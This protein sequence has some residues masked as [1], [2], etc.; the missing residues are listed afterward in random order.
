MF[1]VRTVV[2]LLILSLLGC[3]TQ[4]DNSAIEMKST[5]ATSDGRGSLGGYAEPDGFYVYIWG[6]VDGSEFGRGDWEIGDTFRA[7]ISVGE[8]NWTN[9]AKYGGSS[10]EI[11]TIVG[12]T[13]RGGYFIAS[14]E[15][16]EITCV[17]NELF[18]RIRPGDAEDVL[19]IYV[20]MPDPQRGMFLARQTVQQMG[21]G[22]F[23]G[24]LE[25]RGGSH[26]FREDRFH[27]NED[28]PRG[29]GELP[30]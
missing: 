18:Y 6:G 27:C 15:P 19:S 21:A 1:Q 12:G 13:R 9:T 2:L 8:E 26:L 3:D 16:Q 17:D 25:A 4:L 10:G 28:E 29:G 22:R 14:S 30:E 20:D 23:L 7:S 24:W 5:Y 11:F